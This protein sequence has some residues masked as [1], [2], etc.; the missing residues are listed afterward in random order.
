MSVSAQVIPPLSMV[1]AHELP[2]STVIDLLMG[3]ASGRLTDGDRAA[4]R[5]SPDPAYAGSPSECRIGL[6]P[7]CPRQSLTTSHFNRPSSASASAV[8]SPIV[9]GS[10]SSGLLGPKPMPTS[11]AAE[12]WMHVHSEPGSGLSNYC[13]R[14]VTSRRN[15]MVFGCPQWRSDWK[16]CLRRRWTR[17]SPWMTRNGHT[18]ARATLGSAGCRSSCAH[19]DG[20]T[21]GAG[22]R[23]RRL[24]SPD[25]RL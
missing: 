2:H 7:A 5:T 10:L 23:E 4:D 1:S 14:L 13:S 12:P 21:D 24:V 3:M 20:S 6:W 15:G 11:R 19:C 9:G 18:V 25:Q 16:R 17:S 8:H 22:E